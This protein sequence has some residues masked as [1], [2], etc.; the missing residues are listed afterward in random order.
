MDSLED[1]ENSQEGFQADFLE[2]Q[3]AILLED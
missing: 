1:K 3:E 2:D